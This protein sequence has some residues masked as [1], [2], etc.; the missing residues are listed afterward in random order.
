MISK[1]LMI[2]FQYLHSGWLLIAE[3][4]SRF[5][6]N[7]GGADP[8]K[9]SKAIC[10]LGFTSVSKVRIRSPHAFVNQ[11]CPSE[12]VMWLTYVKHNVESWKCSNWFIIFA[13]FLEQNVHHVVL[14][15]KGLNS[16]L[17]MLRNFLSLQLTLLEHSFESFMSQASP[18]LLYTSD[19]AD[20]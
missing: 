2:T 7:T 20:E 5:D 19:A 17:L 4:K 10:G 12:Y 1:C 11:K 8:N 13:G 3:V 18:C 15:E 16:S 14:Q 9:F 6:P